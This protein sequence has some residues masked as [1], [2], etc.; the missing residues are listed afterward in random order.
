MKTLKIKVRDL[1]AKFLFWYAGKFIVLGKHY[2]L[3]FDA[4]DSSKFGVKILKKYPDV[5]VNFSDIQV[6]EDGLVEFNLIVVKGGPE[7]KTKRFQRY[8]GLIF[9]NFVVNSIEQAKNETRNYDP[10]EPDAE[11]TVHEEGSAVSEE[12]LHTRKD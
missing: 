6:K 3:M 7:T 2:E 5:I 4:S 1:I 8:V 10:I 12:S 11:R 9:T